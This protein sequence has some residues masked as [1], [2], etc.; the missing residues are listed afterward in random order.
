NG[1][2]QVVLNA[3]V[4]AGAGTVVVSANVQGTAIED[5]AGFISVGNGQAVPYRLTMIVCNA[6]STAAVANDC[7]AGGGATYGTLADVLKDTAGNGAGAPTGRGYVHA[8]VAS[9]P[10]KTSV[11]GPLVELS[12]VNNVGVLVNPTAITNNDGVAIVQLNPGA[13]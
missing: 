6:T 5:S 3:G 11:V 4:N 8:R 7:T 2:A 12:L 9:F 1:Q 10:A 13:V